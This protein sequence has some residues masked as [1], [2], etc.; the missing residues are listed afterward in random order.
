M[1]SQV[2]RFGN[3]IEIGDIVAYYGTNVGFIIGVVVKLNPRSYKVMSKSETPGK[4][5][6]Y[7]YYNVLFEDSHKIVTAKTLAKAKIQDFLDDLERIR[8]GHLI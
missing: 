1:T 8:L 6:K 4:P 5:P 2:D 7:S 3:P